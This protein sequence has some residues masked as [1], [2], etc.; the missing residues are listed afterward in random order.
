M[1]PYCSALGSEDQGAYLASAIVMVAV[2]L[3]MVGL[4]VLWLVW[5]S[6]KA[7]P[8]CED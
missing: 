1:C 5:A 4:L 2:P 8:R 6:K 7:R 3:A